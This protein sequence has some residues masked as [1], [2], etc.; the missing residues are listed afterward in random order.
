[1]YT[2]HIGLL[3]L[4][5]FRP[6]FSNTSR[7][8]IIIMTIIRRRLHHVGLA[9]SVT[10]RAQGGRVCDSWAIYKPVSAVQS[11]NKCVLFRFGSTFIF[12]VFAVDESAVYWLKLLI[13]CWLNIAWLAFVV[14]D[15]LVF[16][17]PGATML[18]CK[19]RTA[20]RRWQCST[21]CLKE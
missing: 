11:I 4:C 10:R 5:Y 20:I 2:T 21:N 3:P 12:F 17:H 14:D 6:H 8:Y 1:M 7:T 15:A 9:L 13:A 19:Q 16:I 18:Q